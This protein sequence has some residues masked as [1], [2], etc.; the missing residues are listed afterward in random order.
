MDNKKYYKVTS[1]NECHQGYQYTDGLNILDKPFEKEGS[2][3]PGGLYFTNLDHIA[4]FSTF[5][6]W[7]REVENTKRCSNGSRFRRR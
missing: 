7:L 4:K 6:V 5:G 1:E 3:V 2:C